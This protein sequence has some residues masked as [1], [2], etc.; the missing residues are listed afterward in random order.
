MTWFAGFV[1]W[2]NTKHLHLHSSLAYL[3]P[4][5]RRTGQAQRLLELRNLTLAAARHKHPL[6]W[7]NRPSKVY[8]TPTEVVLNGAAA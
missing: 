3:T 8:A 6:R 2:Y 4:Q 1:D 5:Q 7:G